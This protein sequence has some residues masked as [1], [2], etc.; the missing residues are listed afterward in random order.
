MKKIWILLMLITPVLEGC[1]YL[2]WDDSRTPTQEEEEPKTD[3]DDRL[4]H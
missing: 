2:G 3:P 1:S 4:Y